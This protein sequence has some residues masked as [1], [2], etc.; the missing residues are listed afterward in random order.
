MRIVFV[1][2]GLTPCHLLALREMPVFLSD[3]LHGMISQSIAGGR[4]QDALAETERISH[5]ARRA[6]DPHAQAL[7]CLYQAETLYRMFRWEE[8]LEHTRQA[9]VWL[10][11]AGTQVGVYNKAVALYLEG[12]LH[13]VLRADAYAVQAF[14]AAQ[15][16]LM[17]SERFWG[18]EKNVARVIHCQTLTRWMSRLLEL[19]PGASSGEWVM[20]V[21]LYEPIHCTLTLVDALSIPPFLA[22][23]PRETLNEC[24]PVNY[25]P[26]EIEAIRFFQ[27]WPDTSY[28]ALKISRDGELVHQSRTGDVLLIEATSS[29]PPEEVT[30]THDMPFVRRADGQIVF[31]PY[32]QQAEIF[33]GIPRI[34]IK[35]EP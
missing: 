12:L 28:L 16:V 22:Q 20:I 14:T 7:V 19:A 32:E 1:P 5:I 3:Q 34:L 8:A 11:A 17:E 31:G 15:E 10:R 30:L 26:L 27:L 18:F 9:V 4:Y 6:R 33:A 2:V 25:V 23:L 35:K 21:P 29:V 24:L 13:F